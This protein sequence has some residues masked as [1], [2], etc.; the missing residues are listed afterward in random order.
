M[1]CLPEKYFKVG[2][3]NIFV[4]CAFSMTN[5]LY[6]C[7]I[8]QHRAHFDIMFTVT[9]QSLKLSLYRKRLLAL[10]ELE[11]ITNSM[12]VPLNT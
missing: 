9:V 6:F 3:A 7:N 1:W 4:F 2:M 10:E 8:Q 12:Q 11:I 5:L